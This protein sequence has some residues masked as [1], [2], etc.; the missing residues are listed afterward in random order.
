MLTRHYSLS[1][2]PDTSE[3]RITVKKEIGG[4]ASGFLHEQINV[5]DLVNVSMPCGTFSRKTSG[6]RGSVFLGAGVGITALL[7]M[8]KESVK[9]S[10][11]VVFRR[12]I[13]HR[14]FI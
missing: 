7:G 4:A 12:F 2:D 9:L 10:E 8:I 5:G 1:G 11:Q 6:E 14:L 3:Y 13:K